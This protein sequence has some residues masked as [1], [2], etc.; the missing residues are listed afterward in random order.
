[1]AVQSRHL[2]RR[3]ILALVVVLVASACGGGGGGGGTGTGGQGGTPV[4][5]G[6]L[7]IYN[8]DDVDF[9]DTALGYY[10][11]TLAL[12]RTYARTLYS[13]DIDKT[14]AAHSIPVPDLADGEAKISGNNTVFAFK[15]RKG[16]G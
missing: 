1:M 5:G 8:Q 15:L 13:W 14:G 3:T 10:T 7:H 6:T 16:V 11:V 2:L 12:Q 9:L 4:K